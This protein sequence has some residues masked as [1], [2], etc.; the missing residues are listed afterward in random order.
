MIQV[1]EAQVADGEDQAEGGVR[2]RGVSSGM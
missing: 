2:G 1:W